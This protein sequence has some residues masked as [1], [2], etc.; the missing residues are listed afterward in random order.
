MVKNIKNKYLLAWRKP[1]KFIIRTW[2][3][4]MGEC[5]GMLMSPENI[6]GEI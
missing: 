1:Y 4:K 5:F 2:V 6:L 3:S